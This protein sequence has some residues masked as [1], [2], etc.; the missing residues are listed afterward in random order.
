MAL[1]ALSAR[2]LTK[3]FGGIAAVNNVSLELHAGE[4]TGLLG[5]N[6]S[7]KTTLMSILAGLVRPDNGSV[8]VGGR[9]VT[10][11]APFHRV[12]RTLACTLQNPRLFGSLTVRENLELVLHIRRTRGPNASQEIT[13]ILDQLGLSSAVALRADALS[14]GQRKLV[15]LARALLARPSVL[16]ADEP[17]SGVSKSGQDRMAAALH[18]AAADGTA[19]LLVSHDLPWTFANCKSI[20]FMRGGEVVVHGT[21][22]DV[23]SDVRVVESYLR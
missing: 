13:R 23:R 16:L 7:G 6:G 22:D 18:E 3:A 15:D 9:N 11:A 4:L 2:E 1:S 8:Q 21:P 10:R 14:G 20:L 19:I 5:P 12:R 17:T